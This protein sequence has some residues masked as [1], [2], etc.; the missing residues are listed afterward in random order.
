ML[1]LLVKNI[2]SILLLYENCDHNLLQEDGILLMAKKFL[3]GQHETP[4]GIYMIIT[5]L[6]TSTIYVYK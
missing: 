1:F 4:Q 2:G 5:E 6:G 3:E